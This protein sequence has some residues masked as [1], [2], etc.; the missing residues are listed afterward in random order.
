VGSLLGVAL[1]TSPLRSIPDDGC[2]MGR[3]QGAQLGAD[4]GVTMVWMVHWAVAVAGLVGVM[5]SMV[6]VA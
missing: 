5:G 4:Q 6:V 3:G 1:G 2:S